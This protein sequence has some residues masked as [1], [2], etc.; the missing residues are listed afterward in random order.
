MSASPRLPISAF[1][2]ARNEAE[3]IGATLESLQGL[4]DEVIVVE[5]GSTDA[6]VAVAERHG[7]R[8]LHNRWEGYGPQKRFA[9]TCCRN[10]WLLNL[11][12]DE[13]L[14]SEL[15]SELWSLFQAGEPTCDA[16]Q[17]V[18][19][20]VCPHETRPRRWAYANSPIR[21]YDREHGRFSDSLVHDSV[22]MDRGSVVGKL[23][24]DV[25][26]RGMLSLDQLLTKINGYTTMQAEDYLK[27]KSGAISW[28]RLLTV[29][30]AAFLKSFVLRRHFV[31]G[32]YGLAI[33][34]SYA[35]ARL[36]RLSKIHE[37]QLLRDAVN[38]QIPHIEA[39][40]R[41]AA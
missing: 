36:L 37:Q 1:V 4:V 24:G 41:K 21:L 40:T 20:A 31:W 14:S 34:A 5:W 19:R 27:R 12:A 30:P 29:F 13:A 28:W 35:F 26:H 7:A 2:I 6:T 8:V 16:Y 15:Q 38:R 32:R 33:S 3:R 11:D 9:E 17:L 22:L 25:Y 23:H 18:I 10:R 39:E